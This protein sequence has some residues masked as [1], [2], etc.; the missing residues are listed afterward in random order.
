MKPSDSL[1]RR[2]VTAY[3]LF[4]L[5]CSLFFAIVTA[6]IVEG[7]EVRLVDE[8]LMEVAAWASP[9][10]A[11]N[12]PV[13][14][15][16]GMS[17]H[18][19][20]SIPVSLRNLPAGVQDI[21]V[22]GTDLIVLA[23]RDAAG[24]FVV[25]DHE[26]D[27]EA[28]ELAV[29]SLL[30]VGLLGF[31][32]LSLLLGVFVARRFVTPIIKLSE[33]VAERR[34]ELPLQDNNDE[35]GVLARAFAAHTSEMQQFLDRERFFTGDVSHELRTPLTVISGAAEILM[36]EAAG[37]S[38]LY[39]PAERIYRAS[40]GAADSVA[41][42]LLLAR[43]PTLIESDEVSLADVVKEE[44]ALYQG[45]V[46][47][48]PVTLHYGGGDDFSVRAPRKLVC[49]AIGNL[50]RNACQYTDEGSVTVTLERDCVLVQ[51]TGRGLPEQVRAMLDGG[52]GQSGQAHAGSAGT[53]LGLALVKRICEYLG[54]TLD[55]SAV[56]SKGTAFR[57]RF[58][59]MRDGGPA[60]LS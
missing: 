34:P 51:D 42:L 30:G 38:V 16:A 45:L 35:L 58:S 47:N 2:I 40:L 18:H 1:R 7:I 28:V 39:G 27:Y 50:I 11:A 9:R 37:N 53:G 52:A 44:V 49:A 48:K 59:D 17:F 8:R 46:G 56:S 33:A 57:I 43:S 24:P 26:S 19:G 21:E 32:G 12:L 5:A 20:E 13:E 15:P 41:I 29:Y 54:A 6:V 22:D 4:A 55:V 23:G 60:M 14:M 3:L 36:I 10:H 31:I 25:V